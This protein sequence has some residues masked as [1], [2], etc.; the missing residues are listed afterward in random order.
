MELDPTNQLF[1]IGY[2]L[3]GVSPAFLQGIAMWYVTNRIM[4]VLR[5]LTAMK[6]VVYALCLPVGGTLTWP[7]PR[8]DY[9]V[10]VT[11]VCE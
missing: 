6:V 10:S 7:A 8:C 5:L 1:F 9:V 4:T 2:A 11:A 3:I